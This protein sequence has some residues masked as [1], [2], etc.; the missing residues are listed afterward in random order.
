MG[1]NTEPD[2]TR[3][4]IKIMFAF[5]VLFTPLVVWEMHKSPSYGQMMLNE[6]KKMSFH[7]KIDSAYFDKQNHNAEYLILTDGFNYP[8]YEHWQFR[9]QKGDSIAKDTGELF[10]RVFKRNGTKDSLDYKE[11][12]KIYK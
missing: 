4:V 10:V 9:L 2:P 3:I 1:R 11:L 8:L 5:L 6:A 7:G 12:V